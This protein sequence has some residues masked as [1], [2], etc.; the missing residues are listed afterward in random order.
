MLCCIYYTVLTPEVLKEEN[1]WF[2]NLSDVH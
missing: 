1:I 2:C